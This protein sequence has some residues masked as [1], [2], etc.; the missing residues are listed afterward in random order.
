MS[1]NNQENQVLKKKK[2]KWLW[3]WFLHEYL[4]GHASNSKADWE[5]LMKWALKQRHT[6]VNEGGVEGMSHISGPLSK[7]C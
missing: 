5:E 1:Y 3:I 4:T 6:A 2:K 7:L